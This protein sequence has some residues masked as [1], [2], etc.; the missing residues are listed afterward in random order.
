MTSGTK[1]VDLRVNDRYGIKCIGPWATRT[2]SGGDS[3][4][5]PKGSK[6]SVSYMVDAI[7]NRHGKVIRPAYEKTHTWYDRPLP[8]AR[9][10]EHSYSTSGA[11][12]NGASISYQL[13]TT[14]PPYS[15]STLPNGANPVVLPTISNPWTAKDDTA[16]LAKLQDKIAGSDFDLGVCL[17]EGR[18]TLRMIGNSA[19]SIAAA[20]KHVKRGNFP[21]AA[22]VIAHRN[23]LRGRKTSKKQLAAD[24]WLELQYGIKPLLSDV[25]AGAQYLAHQLDTAMSMRVVVNR[26]AQG[27]RPNNLPVVVVANNAFTEFTVQVDSRK[28]II[29]ILT[30]NNTRTLQYMA[31]PLTIAWELMPYSFVA[32]W[33]LPIG[34]Y[35]QARRLNNA[36]TA[37]YITMTKF[38]RKTIGKPR[39]VAPRK[40]QFPEDSE[41][42]KYT[43]WDFSR[44][45]STSLV[46]LFPRVKPLSSIASWAHAENACALL[47]NNFS[48][49]TRP[50]R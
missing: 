15:H 37:K 12:M 36:V 10:E 22:K 39:V 8:R 43:Q 46:P 38:S 26:I 27:K 44:T 17:G 25:E 41:R 20:L 33:F 11:R 5:L 6:H 23:S 30:E 32:D 31:D 50:R 29:A 16:L 21:A 28:R 13:G 48:S 7:V 24:N 47:V 42:F 14:P 19:I 9:Q 1:S 18:E 35:L 4:P 3:T 2:W 45:I 34:S 40:I 49:S